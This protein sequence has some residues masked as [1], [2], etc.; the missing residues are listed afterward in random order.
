MKTLI[1]AAAGVALLA[2]CTTTDQYGYTQ[3]N[4]MMTG[5]ILGAIAGCAT[6]TNSG[7][8]CAK[9]AAIGALAGGAVGAYMD[10]Q[11][12][13]LE[14]QLSNTGVGIVR[15]GDSIYLVM[16]SDITFQTASASVAPGFVP[17]LVDVAATLNEYPNTTISVE[18]HADKR[19]DDSY[20][21]TLSRQR[22]ENVGVVLARQN[23]MPERLSVT[24]YGETRPVD[25][26]DNDAAYA[27]N[28]RVE[29]RIVPVVQ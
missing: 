13:K 27:R 15:D 14:Q 20:N 22:A 1:T 5:A 28:R 8:Q 11:Q 24:G 4:N 7:E 6:N 16:P 17:V 10:R 25:Y 29:I 12:R 18:G 19:G 26:G 2:A 9:N 23:V 21:M 3:R